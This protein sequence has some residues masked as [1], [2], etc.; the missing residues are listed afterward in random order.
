MRILLTSVVLI[1]T[2]AAFADTWITLPSGEGCWQNNV[3]VVYGCSGS[4]SAPETAA[5][6]AVRTSREAERLRS[7]KLEKCLRTASWPGMPGRA[8]CVQMYGP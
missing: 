3:G 2:N 6:T 7:Q 5:Q 4:S 1:I 8:E